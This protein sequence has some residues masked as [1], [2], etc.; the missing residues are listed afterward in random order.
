MGVFDMRSKLVLGFLLSPVIFGA[1][2][3]LP[4]EK[5]SNELVEVSATLTLDRQEIRQMLGSDLGAG[6]VVVKVQLRP[7]S[8][9]PI[10]IHRDDF[11]LF[12]DKDGQR[13]QP[14]APSQI[15]GGSTL[16]VSSGGAARGATLGQGNGPIWGGIPGGGS[17]QRLPGNGGMAGSGPEAGSA[18][19]T[20]RTETASG[21]NP[22]LAVLK[23][24]ELP[25][26]EIT[27][28]ASGLL[29]FQMEGKVKPKDLELYYRTP[30]G[31]LS[32]R[33]RP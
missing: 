30:S 28:N 23:E 3:K 31:K 33:F 21:E 18:E 7:L 14:F 16:V 15:A 26:K 11:V 20:V 6:I 4:I 25:Q 8:D 9:K 10:A 13:S 5:N 29:Y 17:P 2:K 24:K 22:V 1:D 19:S 32:L 12:S 27:D